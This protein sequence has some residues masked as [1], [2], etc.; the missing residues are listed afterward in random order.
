M[1]EKNF[2]CVYWISY[3]FLFFSFCFF[4]RFKKTEKKRMSKHGLPDSE[5]E[6]LHPA[7]KQR[8]DLTEEQQ[9]E[10]DCVYR[11]DFNDLGRIEGPLVAA[12]ISKPDQALRML[13]DY[14]KEYPDIP[15]SNLVRA[16]I[17][18]SRT[19]EFTKR[20]LS[21]PGWN[22]VYD[23]DNIRQNFLYDRI[24]QK[25][26]A[27]IINLID[28]LKSMHLPYQNF[29]DGF[30][31]HLAHH[32]GLKFTN[33][34]FYLAVKAGGYSPKDLKDI[35]IGTWV[36]NTRTKMIIQMMVDFPESPWNLDMIKKLSSLQAP[37]EWVPTKFDDP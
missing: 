36:G 2:F 9:K 11:E 23:R 26:T 17:L 27:I 18:T 35:F 4:F 19:K 21:V 37:E 34:P 3:L 33:H 30:L 32:Y 31:G 7:K 20:V 16:L 1:I 22:F 13:E 15:K 24:S 8:Y 28:V 10:F 29:I 12:S 25:N 14:I 5:S 6:T